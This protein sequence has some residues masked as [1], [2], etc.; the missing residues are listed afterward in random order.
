MVKFLGGFFREEK[1]SGR[2]AM[3]KKYEHF[4]RLLASNNDTLEA[5]AEIEGILA[6]ERETTLEEIRGRCRDLKSDVVR[7]VEDLDAIADGRYRGLLHNVDRIAAGVEDEFRQVRGAPLTKPCIP[8]EEIGREAADAVGGK[9]SNLGEVRNRIG[10]PVPEGFAITAFAYRAFVEGSGLQARLDEL[11]ERVD[12]DDLG[13]LTRVSQEMQRLVRDA[14]IPQDVDE[15]VTLAAHDLY[16][17]TH[18]AKVSIRSS[19]IGED[20][21]STFAGQYGTFLN[22]PSVRIRRWYKEV[23]ASKFTPRAIFYMHTHGFHER[24]VAMSV[25]VFGMLD[26]AAAG[27]AYSVDPVDP[28]LDKSVISAVW[29]LGKPVVDGTMTPDAYYVSR[30]PGRGILERR[31]AVKPRR[32]LPSAGEG[33]VEMDVPVS[34]QREPCLTNEQI[35]KL[36][37]YMSALESHYRRPQDLEWVLDR[38]GHLFILQTRPLRLAEHG[39]ARDV[40]ESALAGYPIALAGG[41]TASPG[42]GSGPVV[43]ADPDDELGSFPAGGVLAARQPSPQF[44]KVMTK[45]AA[46]VTDLGSPTGH[47]AS[48]A[49]EYRVPTI[50][51]MERAT[52]LPEGTVV[53]VDAT[54]ARVFR[55]RVEELLTEAIRDPSPHC[56]SRT[57]AVLERVVARVARLNLTDPGKNSFRAKNCTTYHDVVRFCHEMA[58]SE[59]FNLNDYL[60]LREKGMAFRLAS[61]IPLGIY[62]IDLGGG[63]EGSLDSRA[64]RPEQIR[65]APMRALWAGMTTPGVRWAG[66]RPIDL[67]GFLSVWANTMYD[68]ARGSR[69]LGDNSYAILGANYLSFGSRLGYHFT[70]LDS[71]CGE[72]VNENHVLFRFKGGAADIERRVRRTRFVGEVLERFGFTV[73]QNGDL[74]NAWVKKLPQ[75]L[76]EER[77]T[78]IG[79]LIGCARQLDIMMDAETT[80][81]DCI[82]A[83]LRGD[84][85]FFDFK[86]EP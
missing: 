51:A 42:V 15:A 14:R 20:G 50:T 5:I 7:L 6:S 62:V 34:L 85:A 73:D 9:T 8:L 49:R 65:S 37:D 82:E 60:N 77:L 66:A 38:S 75:P 12:W 17:K 53:T 58:I 40:D 16:R 80:L 72:T 24:D 74:L 21:R 23:L 30:R 64:V 57:L 59:M 83:F 13:A 55:G 86:M 47:M 52:E 44:V 26:A 45:A 43:H 79:R 3:R 22:V 27:V 29:G 31:V 56:D 39:V 2:E 71:V 78:T 1:P 41:L 36:A 35:L 19:A 33:V 4:R 48:L 81:S 67:R 54:R 32:L 28:A 63:L 11:W 84:Y 61:D 18:G 25:G 76:I 10:L 70:T 68:A 46:I 69:G